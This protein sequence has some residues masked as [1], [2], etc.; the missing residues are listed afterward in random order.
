MSDSIEFRLARIQAA[1][2][3]TREADIAKFP[4]RVYRSDRA[5]GMEHDFRGGYT[6]A[7]LAVEANK[8]IAE[9]ASVYYHVS[10]KASEHG[11]KE[12]IRAVFQN[13][14]ILRI[15]DDLW[16][17]D[18]HRGD[19]RDGGASKLNPRIVEYERPLQLGGGP[20]SSAMLTVGRDG[21]PIVRTTGSG[22]AEVV[23]TGTVVNDKG[24][25]IGDLRNILT[26]AI[27]VWEEFFR[28]SG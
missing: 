27:A 11:G 26:Q 20:G 3:S 7:M 19:K 6:D 8:L 4:P 16:N 24:E 21:R 10:G 25:V 23:V 18:K 5:F 12:R 17:R 13:S 9:V 1:I 22:T 2:G 15:V 14:L 28:N